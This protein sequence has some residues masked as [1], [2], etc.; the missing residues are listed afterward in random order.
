MRKR[1][2]DFFKNTLNRQTRET[3]KPDRISGK[4]VR[5]NGVIK[6]THI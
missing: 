3:E 2:T 5:K 6:K 4:G 1:G